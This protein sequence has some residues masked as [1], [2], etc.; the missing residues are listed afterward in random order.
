MAK[1][2]KLWV[3]VTAVNVANT[4]Y[5][6]IDQTTN[7]WGTV[8]DANETE[9]VSTDTILETSVSISGTGWKS[10]TLNEAHLDFTKTL[11]VRL[12]AAGEGAYN[13]RS[14]T[15]NSQNASSNKPYLEIIDL[16]SGKSC[17]IPI[18]GAG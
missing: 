4:V 11:W 18:L 15:I 6:K 17:N 12:H 16:S 10:F 14:I 8:L 2:I 5:L 7:N 3:Y 9:F 13:T 1:Q